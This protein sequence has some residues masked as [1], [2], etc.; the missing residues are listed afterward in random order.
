MTDVTPPGAPARKGFFSRWFGSPADVR[1]H[2]VQPARFHLDSAET[3]HPDASDPGVI[4]RPRRRT[5]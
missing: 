1:P 3:W 4:R 2:A 5:R